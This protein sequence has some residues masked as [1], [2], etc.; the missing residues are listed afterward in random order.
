[1]QT[2]MLLLGLEEPLTSELAEALAGLDAAVVSEPSAAPADYLEAIDRTAADVVFCPAEP[3]RYT[4]LIESLRA[5]RREVAVVVVSCHPEID[6]WLD[7]L[8]AGASDYC[9]TPFEPRLLRS[10]VENAVKHPGT[11]ALA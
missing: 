2:K 5:D 7:A 3:E 11:L 9:A 1:M 10:I 6:R 4:A 8:D